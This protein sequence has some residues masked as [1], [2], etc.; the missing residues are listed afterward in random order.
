[1]LITRRP[2]QCFFRGNPLKKVL[3]IAGLA[4]A[5]AAAGSPALAADGTWNVDAAGN[6]STN[7]SW[8]GN[9]IPGTT[10]GTT[11][12]DT[13]WFSRLLTAARTVTV[14]SSRNIRNITF[15]GSNSGTWGYTLSGGS[16]LLTS[17]GT[18]SATGTAGAHTDTISA[19]MTILGNNATYTIANDSTLNTRLLSIT[20]G[21]TGQSVAGGTTTLVLGGSNA[22]VNT[23]ANL[24]NGANGG[25]IGITKEG[26]TTWRFAKQD[27]DNMRLFSGP[28]VINGGTLRV[29]TGA[30]DNDGSGRTRQNLGAGVAVTLA[31][32]AGA[33][34]D[35]NSNNASPIGSL[36]GGG[37]TGG[38]VTV[39][40]QTLNTGFNNTNTSFG[41]SIQSTGGLTKVGTGIQTLSGTNG[42]TGTTTINGGGGI[43]LNFSAASTASNIISASSG[44][45]LGGGSFRV[46]GKGST[47]NSQTMASITVGSGANAVALDANSATSLLL[48]L[49]AITRSAGGTL[50]LTLPTGAPSATNGVR[51]TTATSMNSVLATANSNGIAYATVGGSDWAG[52]SSGNIVAMTSYQ[53]GNANYTTNNNVDVANGD[54]PASGVTVNTLRF[55]GNNALNLAGTN[56]VN[57]GGILVT[58]AA[59]AG[60]TISGGTLRPGS[61][62]ELVMINNGAQFTVGSIIANNGANPAALTLSGT[63][64]TILNGLNTY[65]GATT[66]NNGTVRAGSTQALGMS[67]SSAVTIANNPSAVLDLNGNDLSIASLNGTRDTIWGAPTAGGNGGTLALGA[68]SLTVGSGAFGGTI[69]GAGGRLVKTGAGTLTLSGSS[70]FTGGITI[71]AGQVSLSAA[72][73]R[74]PLG[75][76][77]V[78][79]G[80]SDGGSNNATLSITGGPGFT[81]YGPY[82][83]NNNIVLAP[84]T[85]GT[86]RIGG[87]DWGQSTTLNG[88]VTGTNN[89]VLAGGLGINNYNY[90]INNTGNLTVT[91]SSSENTGGFNGSVGSNVVDVRLNQNN[92]SNNVIFTASYNNTG[93]ITAAGSGNKD[94]TL[95]GVIGNTTGVTQ[96]STSRLILGA[97]NTYT[98]DTLVQSG[99]LQLNNNLSIQNS[100]FDT[101][102]AGVLVLNSVTTPTFGGLKGSTS[103]STTNVTGYG[104]VTALTL[105]PQ[106]GKSYT[107]SGN[108]GNGVA[109]MTLTKS[110]S[111]TQILSGSN[112]YSGATTVS[113]GLL[114]FGRVNSLYGGT[115]AN[116]TATNIRTGSGATLAFNVGGSGEFSTG[117]V[118][119]LLTNLASSTSAT[120]GMRAG[121]IFGFDTT[122][123]SGG[124]FTIADAIANS[125]GASGG[126]RGLRKLGTNTLLLSASNSFTGAT[127]VEGGTLAF[128]RVTALNSSSGIGINAG[129]ILDYTGT[130]A[131]TL[132]RNVTVATSGTGTIRNSGGQKLTLSGVLTKDGRVLRLTG[133]QFD[134]TGQIVGASANSDLL[135]DGTSTVTLLTANTYNGPTFVNQSSNLIVGINN[136]IPNNSIVTLGNATTTGTLSLGS[137]SNAI[138]GLVFSGSGGA[139][140]MA[141]TAAQTSA[142]QV[143]ATGAL[144]LNGGPSTLDLAGMATGSGAYKLISYTS[145][146]GT[147]ATVAGLDP[148]YLLRYD[149]VTANEITAQRKAEFGTIT[150][151]PA[152]ATIITGGSTAF[153]YTAAN[154]TPTGGSTLS[155]TSSNG[156]NVAGASSGSA[157]ANATSSSISGL[158]FTGT[159]VG[160]SQTGSFTLTDPDAIGSPAAGTVTVNVLNH[161]LASFDATNTASKT[162]NFGSYDAGSWSGGDG[163][164]GTLAYSIFNIASLGFTDAQ[165]AGLDLYSWTF[166]SGDDI[167]GPGLTAFQNLASG[168]SNGFSASVLSPGTLA[169]RSYTGTYTLRFRDVNLPGGT[170]TRDLALT[171]NVIVVPEPGALALAGIGI[172]AAAYALRS[173]SPSRQRAG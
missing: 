141:P 13:A 55:N 61:G 6:W 111:G 62:N 136:A 146:T 59:T 39:G 108:I 43:A 131:G 79:L 46:T 101:S 64:T 66:V 18:I 127:S 166:T 54:S 170:N 23:I 2:A 84:T 50:D 153:G 87:G 173:R 82:V 20:G 165:T 71:K 115:T 25:T 80:D 63:G 155:F 11:S 32:V 19:P 53:T 90:A 135:V 30:G 120:N 164:N 162:L 114:Q 73:G 57:T 45:S 37:S 60:A 99:T 89:L 105:N 96:N 16:L 56:T 148:N 117:N 100:A 124:T 58:N 119:T 12:T 8:V 152:A 98:G 78:T 5:L 140:R 137:F 44:L 107:Y 156:L 104:S 52:L 41:G 91:W 7:G 125:T 85:T 144:T 95:N 81:G 65:T 74:T 49:N 116:W 76:G 147:F 75:T 70:S 128:D 138:G 151:T 106:S 112:S 129:T 31:D 4:T 77:T 132:S 40:N 123:A 149:T 160:L 126:A 168:T 130:T 36:A 22:G 92:S 88:T 86:L 51:T 35:I 158:V 17:G 33:T 145:R 1:M 150:A 110:G 157:G 9:T 169:E 27:Q 118:T 113:G 133:G 67:G 26:S 154:A 93:M 94:L 159:S 38:N 68:S 47:V 15:D 24:L 163:G 143:S 42:Y 109:G 172:A 48:N 161:S 134:V 21:I 167:F 142:V 3:L 103:L 10:T 171:M 139:L 122:N 29:N 102:G 28:I 34:L 121:S 69:T 97:A 14:D 72:N 83:I